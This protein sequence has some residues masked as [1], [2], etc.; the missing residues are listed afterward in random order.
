MPCP[1]AEHPV[2]PDAWR[3]IR[4]R[5]G[6][7]RCQFRYAKASRDNAH[8]AYPNSSEAQSC[9]TA[10]LIWHKCGEAPHHAAMT[11]PEG[12]TVLKLGNLCRSVWQILYRMRACPT[13]RAECTGVHFCA[14]GTTPGR[15]ARVAPL[16]TRR[17][18]SW[19]ACPRVP[20][21][22]LSAH[23]PV[24]ES[25]CGDGLSAVPLQH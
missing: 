20:R 25:A 2:P 3:R 15:G 4:R 10:T 22:P 6:V 17:A 18:S 13:R 1:G 14:R 16:C 5:V 7:H 19:T 24:C 21:A 12:P 9:T 8:R 11:S 23:G